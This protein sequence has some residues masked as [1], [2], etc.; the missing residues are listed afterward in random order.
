MSAADTK[1]KAGT[2]EIDQRSIDTIRTLTID[3]VQKANSGHAGAPL[4]LA[5]LKLKLAD[6]HGDLR[7]PAALA[8]WTNLMD[9]QDIATVGDDLAA[10]Y[11]PNAAGVR[12]RD[13]GLESSTLPWRNSPP[14]VDALA[15]VL[16][17]PNHPLA[18]QALRALVA[19]YPELRITFHEQE[20]HESIPRL[21][22]RDVDVIVINDWENAPIALPEGLTRAPLFDVAPFDVIG[23]PTADGKGAELWTVTPKGTIAAQAT[24]TLA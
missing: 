11:A 9:R 16:P 5:E 24:A 20:P 21:V 17:N 19:K 2:S 14:G 1:P 8:A 10:L 7:V 15:F 22:R 18:P 12:V 13:V 3:A 6:E 23:R 4:G